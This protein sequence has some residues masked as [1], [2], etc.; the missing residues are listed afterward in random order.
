MKYDIEAILEMYEDDY[1][2]SSKVPGPRN[3]YNQGQLVSNTVDGSRPGYSGK[4]NRGGARPNTG[5]DRS[6]FIDYE[7]RI[8][9]PGKKKLDIA[10]KVHGNKPEYKGLKGF[11]LWKKLE[12]FQR[13][14]IVQESTT[15]E[16]G[17]KPK[18]N[19]I[20]KDDFIK[21]VSDN[22]GKTYNEFVEIIKKYKTKDGQPFTK[23]IIAD[24]LR[25]YKLSGSFKREEPKGPDNIKKAE[26]EKKRKLNLKEVDR[27]KAKGVGDFQY[28]HVR[29]IAGG[30]PLTTDDVLII[31]KRINAQIGGSTNKTLNRI[32]EAIR[33]NNRLALEAMNAKNEG[34][35]LDYIKRVDELN[36]NAE[37]IVNSAIDKLPKKYKGYVGFNQVTLPTNEYGLPISNE[38]MI[39]KKVG[40][41][42][43]SKNAI[44]LT[45]LNLEQ[46]AEFRKIVRE[47]AAAGKTGKINSKEM[48]RLKDAINDAVGELACG[49]KL[50]SG[51]R[52]K[53]SSG[54]SCNV[55]GRKILT[56]AMRNGISSI[57]PSKQNLVKRIL[58]GSANLVKGVL[59]PKEFLKL[60]N[61]IGY[62]AAIAAAVYDTAMVTDD[63]IRKGQPFD[64]A[65]G[66]ELLFGQLN[67]QPQVQEA[68]RVLADPKSSLS[69]AAK[70]YAKM[71]VDIGEYNNTL[72]T[73]NIPMNVTG[74]PGDPKEQEMLQKKL[75]ALD[76]KI[77]NTSTSG[78]LDY[79]KEITERDAKDKAG[80]YIGEPISSKGGPM[81]AKDGDGNLIK[82]NE[83]GYGRTDLKDFFG[84]APDKTGAPS[85]FSGELKKSYGDLKQEP[86]KLPEY[87]INMIPAYVSQN[88]KTMD[89][90]PLSKGMIDLLTKY[91][92]KK[93]T[94]SADQNLD[95]IYFM[96]ERFIEGPDGVSRKQ[97]I[98]GLSPLEEYEL[99]NK[100]GQVL[101]QPGMKGTQ[102]S[103]GG[104]TGLRS[105]YEYKK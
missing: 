23:Q 2:P 81:Y 65:A 14:N 24:R 82:V 32:S 58:S 50:A 26:T 44:D 75:D 56:D 92:R 17:F 49:N 5:G 12:N 101:S 41:M 85:F 80:R 68:K 19:Q 25:S 53:F 87:D 77:L 94:I 21:L 69:P 20:G 48:S 47:Q 6:E 39:I 4:E 74:M 11:E 30:V 95:D 31:N 62:P 34:L 61:L 100:F 27:T 57:E 55:R 84:D 102:F 96:N 36:A 73:K 13:S 66:N 103:E 16:P 97:K 37:K 71:L 91:E 99:Q 3:M 40:G 70:K 59:N 83:Y 28:H 8:K 78:E 89:E 98:K 52:I 29:Q 88:Y 67:L 79:L 38:P 43:V 22:K 10:E 63:M 35:A 64:E 54:S 45:T 51:G 7:I 76:K 60:K 46:E 105:K 1:N 93:G 86:G 15:G 9:N 90:Q 33:K 72:Q 42:P 18:K 104:I